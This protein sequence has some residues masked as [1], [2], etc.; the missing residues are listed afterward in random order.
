MTTRRRLLLG[1]ALFAV[2]PRLG[3]A[4][5]RAVTIGVLLAVPRKQS[6][7]APAMMRRLGEL[8]YAE[9]KR[10]RFEFRSADLRPDRY[11]AVARELVEMKCDLILAMGPEQA[12]LALKNTGT[13]IPIVFFANDYDPIE[14]GVVKSLARPEG[15]ITGVLV[16]Q[17]AL[18]IKRFEVM[19]EI[20]P[21]ARRFLVFSDAFSKDQ[22]REVRKVAANSGL[23]VI[24]V[25]FSQ[26]PYDLLAALKASSNVDGVIFLTSPALYAQLASVREE[27]VKRRLPSIG[28]GP[29]VERGVLLGLG[30]AL[31]A[32]SRAGDMAARILNGAKPADLPVEQVEVFD[33]VVNA[34]AARAMELKIPPTL[35]ARATRIVQ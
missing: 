14:K 21:H 19:R 12:I 6:V 18:V 29:Y 32:T 34:T 1:G 22:L 4:Q 9:G 24:A 33:F 25:E 15:N 3:R 10:A 11:P 20:A 17:L 27:L 23:E 30:G 8:G 5:S 28:V 26:P 13:Q 35:A 7:L 16:P 2:A 31:T